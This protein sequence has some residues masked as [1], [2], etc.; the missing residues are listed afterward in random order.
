MKFFP[1]A[2]QIILLFSISGCRHETVFHKEKS[3]NRELRNINLQQLSIRRSRW[4]KQLN[5][6]YNKAETMGDIAKLELLLENPDLS[7][8]DK[9]QTLLNY[10]ARGKEKASPPY[11]RGEA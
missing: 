7:N 1:I 4:L 6:E 8:A 9:N 10:F 5:S 11:F 3:F 2:V